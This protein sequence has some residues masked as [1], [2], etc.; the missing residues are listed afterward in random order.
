[1]HRPDRPAHEFSAPAARASRWAAPALLAALAYLPL[2]LTAPGRVGGDTKAYLT[3]DPARLLARAP[4]LWQ[5][6][7]GTGTVTHQNIGYLWPMGPWFWCSDRLGVPAWVAQ[8]LWL[9]TILFLAGLGARWLVRT[10]VDPRLATVAACFF[11][12]SPYSLHY[13]ERM[14]VLLLPW[15]GLPWMIGLTARAYRRGGWRDPALFALL[16]MSIGGINATSIILAGLAPVLWL[17]YVVAVPGVAGTGGLELRARAGRAAAAALRIGLLTAGTAAWWASGL[18]AQGAFGLPILRY[19]ETYETVANASTAPEV[20]RGFGHWYFYGRD[21]IGPWVVPSTTYTENLLALTLSFAVPVLALAGFV[22]CRFRHRVFFGLLVVGGAVIAV[23]S[24][25][26]DSPSPYGALFKAFT[27]TDTGLAMRSTPRAIPLVVL[28]L[29]IGFASGVR[30]FG[31]LLARRLA[32]RATRASSSAGAGRPVRVQAVVTAGA[33][34][35]VVANL[36]PLW[37]GTM[38]ASTLRR[39][40]DLPQYWLDAAAALDARPHD[41][42]VLEL[43]GIDFA[44]FRWGNPVDPIMPGLIDRPY[45]ARELVPNGSPASAALLLALDRRYQE[46]IAEPEALAPIARLLGV[47]DI[48]L[49][50]D[51]Q[52]ER[53]NTPRPYVMRRSLDAT[54]GLG[55]AT[56]YGEPARNDAPLP[57][58]LLDA[59]ALAEPASTGPASPVAVYGVRDALPIVRLVPAQSPL[60]VAG[61]AEGLV[62]LA[63]EGLLD[64]TQAILFSASYAARPDALRTELARGAT[65]VVTDTNA[66]RALRWG[67]LRENAGY[68]ERADESLL[69]HDPTDNRLEVFPDAG[70]DARTVTVQRGGLVSASAYGNPVSLSPEDRPSLAFDGDPGTAW[71]VAAFAD[72]VGHRVAIDLDRTRAV[73]SVR[74]VQASGNRAVTRVRV[75]AGATSTVVDLGPES[76]ASPGQEVVLG[77]D[78]ASHVEVEILA[79]DPGNLASYDGWSGVGFSEITVPGVRVTETRRLPV[80]LLALTGDADLAHPL[81][82]VVTRDRADPAAGARRD[83]EASLDRTVTLPSA[84]T[85][86]V[87]GTARLAP[88]IATDALDALTRTTAAPAWQVRASSWLPGDRAGRGTEAFDGDTGS[89]W[90]PAMGEVRGAWVEATAPAATSTASVRV[91]FAADGRHSTPA[92]IT[93]LAD[94]AVAGRVAVPDAADGAFGATRS[95]DVPVTA[96]TAARTWRVVVDEVHER[97]TPEWLGSGDYALPPAVAEVAGLPVRPAAVRTAVDTGCRTDLLQVAGR[98]VP[99]RITGPGAAARAGEALDIVG[100]GDVALPAGEVALTTTPG[101]TTGLDLDRV[102]LRSEATAPA[103]APASGTGPAGTGSSPTVRITGQGRDHVDVVVEGVTAPTWLV[104]GQ[105]ANGGW[106]A[107]S[108]ELGDL[109]GPSLVEGFANGWLLEAHDGPVHLQLRW[110]PQ[111]MVWLGLTITSITA[112]ACLGILL[113]SWRRRRTWLDAQPG[114]ASPVPDRPG[115]MRAAVAAAAVCGLVAAVV[116][117]RWSLL[118]LVVA[119]GAALAVRGLDRGDGADGADRR[120]GLVAAAAAGAAPALL[121]VAGAFTTAKEQRGGYRTDFSWPEIFDAVHVLGMLAVAVVFAVVAVEIARSGRGGA[122]APPADEPFGRRPAAGSSGSS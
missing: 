96:G 59:I 120:S 95:V 88:G 101:A 13:S 78:A 108:A 105:S 99:V 54:P 89:W 4:W 47:G 92:A 42:R 112:V 70:N 58:P 24:H 81:L 11:M 79:T 69:D 43:P 93:V 57:Q 118:A 97:R 55:P 34:G 100:C 63:A 111:R 75:H 14:S 109:G 16:T 62:D 117:P 87:S 48:V 74:L 36:A 22:W 1:M 90:T 82:V 68:V 2:L 39:D 115:S 91:T 110:T 32:D 45:V 80:D 85:F 12:L 19:T 25:P 67:T 116:L 9:G 98:P 77:A 64:P 114:S 21:R 51:L 7:I 28:G 33:C 122:P 102:V 38:A 5:P 61:D 3:I 46:G 44:T 103:G 121:L 23:G 53:F 119:A 20:L 113:V 60:V 107:T 76:F 49:R 17:V 18:G 26:F 86:R 52:Y 50:N 83:P 6:E 40:G 94:G 41:T 56:P 37:T 71:R 31:D 66:K 104:L 65:L 27:G 84:R 10:V 8:R 72:A 35:L 15:A 29:A 106:R 73:P 30:A